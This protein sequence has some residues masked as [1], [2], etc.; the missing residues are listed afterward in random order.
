VLRRVERIID[1]QT[2]RMVHFKHDCIILEGV[3][4]SGDYNQYCPRSI[5]P[6][7]REIWLERV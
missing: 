4:C 2:G 1:E 7:W 5:Y 6:F 3:I